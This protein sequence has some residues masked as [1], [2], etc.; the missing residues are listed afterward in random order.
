VVPRVKGVDYVSRRSMRKVPKTV[1]RL[2]W[3][4]LFTDVATEMSYPLLPAFLATMGAAGVWLGW[5]EGVADS[6]GAFVKYRAGAASDRRPARKPFVVF[7]YTL[8]T[9]VRPLLALVTAPWQV[10]ALRTGDRIGKGLRS[11]PRDALLAASAPVD[12]RA[13][14]F[15]IHQ[16]MDNVGAVFG[17]LVAF[18]LARFAQA[19]LREIFGLAIVPGLVAVAVLVFGVEETAP[20]APPKPKEVGPTVP[21]DANIKRYLVAVGI[22]SLGASS[23]AFL[24]LRMTRQHLAVAFLPIAWL[25]LNAVKA[26]TNVAGGRLSD[27]IGHKTIMFVGWAFYAAIYAALPLAHTYAATWV[28]MLGYGFYYGLTEGAEKALM[29]DLASPEQRGRAFGALHAV[30]GAAVLP[31]N[32]VFGMIFDRHPE[33]AFLLG[34]SFAALGALALLLVRAPSTTKTT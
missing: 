21:L 26:L 12:A 25:T 2:G 18:V 5:V 19:S 8:S 11:A 30:T 6:V 1:W 28:V 29:T 24:L 34:A 32:A 22:F 16:M 15:G 3:V 14:S 13:L 31:A 10:V 20:I 17:P 23:D 9:L 4:S 7:G 33:V 27:R